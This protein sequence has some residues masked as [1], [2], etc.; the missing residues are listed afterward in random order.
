MTD[1]GGTYT[2]RTLNT[3]GAVP[4][5]YTVTVTKTETAA[6]SGAAVSMEDAT[7]SVAAGEPKQ[8]LPGKYADPAQSPLKFD[9]TAETKTID[10]KLE[11]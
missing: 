5:K 7:K 3:E 10:L 4:G 8:L 2:L 9:V 11:D 6:A 1:A